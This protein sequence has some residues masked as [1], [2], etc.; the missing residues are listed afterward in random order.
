MVHYLRE[1]HVYFR[2]TC[3][4]EADYRVRLLLDVSGN[5]G[6]SVGS[7]SGAACCT[8]ICVVIR[9]EHEVPRAT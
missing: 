3:L 8:I 2:L 9:P 1:G 7:P 5:H 4:M 6:V